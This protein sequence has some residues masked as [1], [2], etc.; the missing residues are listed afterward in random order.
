MLLFG[1]CVY[2]ETSA[3]FKNH[4][5]IIPSAG[6]SNAWWHFG[7]T[8][9]DN[10]VFSPEAKELKEQPPTHHGIEVFNLSPPGSSMEMRGFFLFRRLA[11]KL[12]GHLWETCCFWSWGRCWASLAPSLQIWGESWGRQGT[13]LAWRLAL[14]LEFCSINPWYAFVGGA[15]AE[16][17]GQISC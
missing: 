5:L 2:T 10:S 8:S 15:E 4:R 9:L 13:G 17:E 12:P 7:I 1:A 16:L 11:R 6:S 14:P 3:S